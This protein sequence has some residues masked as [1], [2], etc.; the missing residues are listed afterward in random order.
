[1]DD[2]KIMYITVGIV[3]VS[4]IAVF[5]L[6]AL[7]GSSDT[8]EEITPER[9]AEIL[10][11]GDSFVKGDEEAP[12]EII[13]FEDF[14]CPF[15]A[16]AAVSIGQILEEYDG[17]V[18]FVFKHFPLDGNIS[19]PAGNSLKASIATEAA[20][21]QG[22]FYEY[23][24]ILYRNQSDWANTAD[25][26]ELKDQ[27]V[28]YAEE[29]GIQDMEKFRNDYDNNINRDKILEDKAEG[30]E[31][32]EI[33]GTPTIFINDRR[34]TSFEYEFLKSEIDRL[35]AEEES[36]TDDE[37][38]VETEGEGTDLENQQGEQSTDE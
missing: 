7:V 25:D 18:K 20:G 32:G 15:C 16:D 28:S 21:V 31:L 13:A 14:E 2:N 3:I 23:H 8:R 24:D 19:G 6:L 1:M 22:R 17:E 29:I 37:N 27:F 34:V 30:E 12:V 5:G 10:S 35:L 11:P 4:V 36:T 26:S 9:R 33:S 38:N